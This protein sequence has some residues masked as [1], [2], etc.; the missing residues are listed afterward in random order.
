M[1]LKNYMSYDAM[2]QGGLPNKEFIWGIAFNLKSEW[3]NKYYSECVKI[4]ESIYKFTIERKTIIVS[5]TQ[6]IKLIDDNFQ[7]KYNISFSI[8]KYD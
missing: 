5:E 3:E 7:S 1:A 6:R 2:E 4:R 8:K